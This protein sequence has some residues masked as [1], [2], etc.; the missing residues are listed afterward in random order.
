[1]RVKPGHNK[2]RRKKGRK[3]REKGKDLE[4]KSS[5]KAVGMRSPEKFQF[6]GN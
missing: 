2:K 6:C 5:Y 4:R 3:K 1:M